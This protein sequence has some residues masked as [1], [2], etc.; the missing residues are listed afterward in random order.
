MVN[1]KSAELFEQAKQLIPGGVNSPVRAFKS[2]GGNPRFIAWAKGSK[3]C[4]VD[5]NEYIDYVGS[6]GPLILGH[7]HPQIV[8]AVQAAAAR[9]T[10]FGAPT[11]AEIELAQLIVAAVPSIQKVRLVNSGTEAT[12]SALRL[13]RGFTGRDKVLKFEGCYHGHVDSLLVKA[14]SGAL[15]LG[16]PDSAGIPASLAG[17]TIIV[18]YNDIESVKQVF[19]EHGREIAAIIVEPIAGNM[20]VI[21]PEPGFLAY[22]REICSQYEA[23][24]I[25]DEVITGFRVAYGGAQQL[26]GIEPDLTC[27]GKIIG[28]GLPIGAYGGKSHIMDVVSPL[29]PVYQ[30][31]TLSG[32]PL[33]V[34]AGIQ[35]LKLLKYPGFYAQ[36]EESAARLAEGLTANARKQGV[37]VRFNRIGSLMCAFFTSTPVLNYA[38]AL[39]AD[40][41]KFARYFWGMQRHG[42]NI[43]PSQFEAM[44]VSCAHTV[45][46]VEKTISAGY[47]VLG[48]L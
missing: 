10:S 19:R 5:G 47:E 14:G 32:N 7:T 4:D 13:A 27:L 11:E 41:E 9:G 45:E 16:V 48:E 28:S 1:A 8:Q 30:A 46:D 17:H 44:F 37:P 38:S 20:G 3:I 23:L 31:G 35:T 25:F 18:P 2:V 34:T 29:G 24:L 36:L 15:T 39:S 26:Y 22:L 43:A 21:P 40:T 42:I 6:W 33:A 12:M